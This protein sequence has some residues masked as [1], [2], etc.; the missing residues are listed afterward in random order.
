[1][2]GCFL[3]MLTIK[4]RTRKLGIGHGCR[5]NLKQNKVIW[6]ETIF[7]QGRKIRQ[8][9]T[10]SRHYGFENELS[11]FT[12]NLFGSDRQLCQGWKSAK[13]WEKSSHKQRLKNL[14]L[15]QQ[16]HNNLS[17]FSIFI[18]Q[19]SKNKN[20]FAFIKGKS[21]IS[22]IVRFCKGLVRRT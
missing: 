13:N 18:W 3:L 20:N 8:K 11:L 22:S 12:L 16:H 4:A 21:S 10:I 6:N 7:S 2:D 17:N 1:M 5:N 19:N 9:I 15:F 14:D